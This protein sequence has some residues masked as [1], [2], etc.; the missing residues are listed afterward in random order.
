[1]FK[2]SLVEICLDH[3][4]FDLVRM[5]VLQ[6]IPNRKERVQS[7]CHRVF[8]DFGAKIAHIQISISIH[9]EVFVFVDFYN[10]H[11]CYYETI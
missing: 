6:V 1:M 11:L 3:R 10:F 4:L 2:S 8:D 9:C 5:H 7:R